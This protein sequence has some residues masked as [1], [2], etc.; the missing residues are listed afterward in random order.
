MITKANYITAVDFSSEMLAKAKQKILSEKVYFHQV[1]ITQAWDFVKLPYQLVCFSLVLEHIENL[2]PIFKEANTALS[3]GGYLY[4]GELHLFKQYTGTK[5]RY[6]LDEGEQ[7]LTC[8]NHHLSDLIKASKENGFE[9]VEI[10]EHFDEADRATI[11]RILTMLFRKL[12][13]E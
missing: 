8:Y 13:P 2:S 1:D 9:I 12:K 3:L 4:I 10:D 5:A 11:P 7:I 6:M